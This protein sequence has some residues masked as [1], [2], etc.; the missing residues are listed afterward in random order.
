MAATAVAIQDDTALDSAVET[1]RF[2]SDRNRLRI[3]GMLM[4]SETC[5]CEI[6][7]ELELPQPLVSYHL[8][9]LRDAGLVKARRKAQW[10]YYSIDP[11]GWHSVVSPLQG[12][13][14]SLDLPEKA[15]YGSSNRCDGMP[16]PEQIAS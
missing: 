5:V 1:L 15:R 3:L 11:D 10:I 9:K 13:F 8:R 16:F 7:D 6:I 2:L 4:D 14:G 12:I